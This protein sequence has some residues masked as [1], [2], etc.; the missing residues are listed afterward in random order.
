MDPYFAAFQA[1]KKVAARFVDVVQRQRA[2][3][4]TSVS[5]AAPSS[6]ACGAS[7]STP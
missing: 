6:M 4:R 2:R 3:S 5:H 1:A 7:N